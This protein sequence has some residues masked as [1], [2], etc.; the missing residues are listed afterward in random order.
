LEDEHKK[1]LQNFMICNPF[2]VQ[3]SIS[4]ETASMKSPNGTIADEMTDE[5][6]VDRILR[7]ETHLYEGLMRKFN[8]RLYR[9]ALSILNDDMEAEDVM[10]TAYINAYL[11]LGNFQRKSAFG[12]WLT[13]ILINESLLQKKRRQKHRQIVTEQQKT[14][15]HTETPLSGLMN[16]EL[17]SLLE[18]AVYNLPEKYRVVFVMRE[19]EEM[20]ISETMEV[21][22]LTESNVKVRLN[23][24]KEMLRT[25]LAAYYKSPSLFEFNLI[26]CD[27]IVN[28]VLN[29]IN[30]SKTVQVNTSHNTGDNRFGSD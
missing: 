4:E 25:E 23:R 29:V 27:R 21:L 18:K 1:G 28:H 16:K 15:T 30:G 11:Q 10:Q 14:E 9:V 22:Q 17:K 2:T 5:E 3:Y 12:T 19:V 20:S 7:G 13:R 6:S 24:A 8:Q 26:R